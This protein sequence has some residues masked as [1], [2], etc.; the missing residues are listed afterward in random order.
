MTDF[1]TR[2]GRLYLN[3]MLSAAALLS[4]IALIILTAAIRASGLAA[5]GA[6]TLL[7]GIILVVLVNLRIARHPTSF[8]LFK[9]AAALSLQEIREL[10]A[11]QGREYANLSF[12]EF[13]LRDKLLSLG[14][15]LFAA[16]CIIVGLRDLLHLN[17]PMMVSD[18]RGQTVEIP[19]LWTG[20]FLLLFG[21]A[22]SWW[23]KLMIYKKEIDPFEES[24]KRLLK[25]FGQE[26]NKPTRR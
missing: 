3:L 15:W 9:A 10:E 5:V 11:R 24:L 17:P 8:E 22:V 26:P 7:A 21:L 19:Q 16:A 13:P 4:L 12:K 23:P 6:F 25:E 14:I 20:I 18:F 1:L 2:R